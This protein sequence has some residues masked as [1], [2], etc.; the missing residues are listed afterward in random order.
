MVAVRKVD[1]YNSHVL[2]GGMHAHTNSGQIKP[3]IS[4]ESVEKVLFDPLCLHKRTTFLKKRLK[5]S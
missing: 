5:R 3:M 1:L 2:F 4:L